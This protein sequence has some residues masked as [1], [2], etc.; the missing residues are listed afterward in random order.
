MRPLSIVI[1]PLNWLYIP[2]VLQ[3]QQ[4]LYLLKLAVVV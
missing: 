2:L 4:I 1:V 3:T